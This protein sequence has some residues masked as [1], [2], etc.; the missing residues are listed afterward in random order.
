MRRRK[1][2]GSLVVLN[3]AALGLLLLVF[4]ADR[5]ALTPAAHAVQQVGIP[6]AGSQRLEMIRELRRLN[7][8]ID[9]LRKSLEKH[10]FEVKVISIPPVRMASE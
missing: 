8:N 6:D 1:C 7:A 2:L 5:A 9:A 4:A 10:E 3:S